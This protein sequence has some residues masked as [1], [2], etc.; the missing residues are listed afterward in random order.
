MGLTST[1]INTW[2]SCR[3]QF[4]VRYMDGWRPTKAS[5]PLLWGQLWH[6]ALE[7]AHLKN[8]LTVSN[9]LAK[10]LKSQCK[11]QYAKDEIDKIYA[12]VCALF[13]IYCDHYHADDAKLKWTGREKTFSIPLTVDGIKLPIRGKRDGDLKSPRGGI[14][15][16]ETK[17]RSTID[18][19]KIRDQLRCD[20]QT[21]LYCWSIWKETGKS[22]SFLIYNVVKRPALRQGKA[23]TK[24]T[25]YLRIANDARKNPQSYFFRW[26][27]TIEEQDLINFEQTI[28]LPVC[29]SFIK[30][31]KEVR[32]NPFLPGR[33]SGV[34]PSHYVNLSALTTPYGVSD[35]YDLMVLRS[36]EKYE[37]Q[38]SP[39]P[40]LEE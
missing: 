22:P 17:T 31:W 34:H 2:L 10:K 6:A 28:L 11:T 1:A 25:F 32:R 40:E 38:S 9:R 14:G 12:E 36:T 33:L 19:K 26:R 3:E 37:L 4:A 24:Q 29:K 16:F 15:L 39:H 13:P 20:F 21:L 5:I 27:V 30:W 8:P 23:E 7:G 35:L 18:P